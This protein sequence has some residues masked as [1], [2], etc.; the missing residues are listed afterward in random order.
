MSMFQKL[1]RSVQIK[2]LNCHF[3]SFVNI[4]EFDFNFSDCKS[5]IKF[6]FPDNALWWRNFA[7]SIKFRVSACYPR[8]KR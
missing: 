1:Y 2:D 4:K 6:N 8:F 7:Q 3:V 5:S